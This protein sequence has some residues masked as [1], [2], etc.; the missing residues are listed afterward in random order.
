MVDEEGMK[1]GLSGEDEIFRS[2]RIV[3]VDEIA[4]GLT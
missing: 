3:D 1:V 4:A 2:K